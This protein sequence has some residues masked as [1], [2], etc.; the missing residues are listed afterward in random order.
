[1]DATARLEQVRDEHCECVEDSKHHRHDATILPRHA[2][3]GRMEFSERTP[4]VSPASNV[5]ERQYPDERFWRFASQA[6]SENSEGFSP[7]PSTAADCNFIQSHC[8]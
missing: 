5:T 2:N 8:L 1:M 4:A 3:S 6:I 7:F